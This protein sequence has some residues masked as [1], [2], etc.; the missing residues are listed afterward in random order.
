MQERDDAVRRAAGHR[1]SLHRPRTC[2]VAAS[3]ADVADPFRLLAD[4]HG[5]Q[6]TPGTS[7]NGLAERYLY[8]ADMAH[9]YAFGR[10][11]GEPDLARTDVWVLLN[12][13]TGDTERRRRPTL[14]R[15]VVRSR[16]DG[17]MGVLVVNLFAHRHTDPRTLR[18][19]ADPVG[20][21]GD[22]ALAL[23]SN[24]GSRTVAAWGGGGTLHGRSMAVAR[25]LD[26]PLCLGTTAAG[27]PRHP[28]YVP[29]GTPLV[30]WRP[31]CPAGT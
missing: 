26:A 6:D 27:Q 5:L 22:D 21:A 24:A 25:L 11:W 12:P 17:R 19:V 8:S 1:R 28:L 20:P 18:M 30:A 13:A 4:R 16:A 31:A 14:D 7:P 2:G 3:V 9:R 10:W 23:L 15:C 29:N